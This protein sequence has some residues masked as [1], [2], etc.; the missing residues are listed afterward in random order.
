M[1]TITLSFAGASVCRY[2]FS[3]KMPSNVVK[4]DGNKRKDDNAKERTL[5][6]LYKMIL[7]KF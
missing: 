2:V 3:G 5:L 6:N 4:V 7:H 1:E